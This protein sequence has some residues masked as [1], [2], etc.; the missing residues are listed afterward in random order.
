MRSPWR[1]QRTPLSQVLS[2]QRRRESVRELLNRAGQI[3]RLLLPARTRGST[4]PGGLAVPVDGLGALY[5]LFGWAA[6]NRPK[7][8]L[9]VIVRF[10]RPQ[11]N[12]TSRPRW[13][14]ARQTAAVVGGTA[15]AARCAQSTV[16]L[17]WPDDVKSACSAWPAGAGAL[18]SMAFPARAVELTRRRCVP[19]HHRRNQRPGRRRG[20]A[21]AARRGV[22]APGPLAELG[23]AITAGAHRTRLAQQHGGSIGPD[24]PGTFDS[25]LEGLPLNRLAPF[26][27]QLIDPLDEIDQGAGTQHVRTLRGCSWHQRLPRRHRAR[28]VPARN[29]VRH[30]LSRIHELTGHQHSCSKT[31]RHS[32]SG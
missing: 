21:V 12:A 24:Q 14:Q 2:S 1:G 26:K 19:R 8:V 30:R 9:D 31:R 20:R 11:V 15:N 16:G 10:V 13:P 25:L 18:L 6:A 7:P 23:S 17:A 22:S 4:E 32:R 27:N 29:T 5:Q 3:A 28:T